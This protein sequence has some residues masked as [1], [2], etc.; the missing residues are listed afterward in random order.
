MT[1]SI[2]LL[3]REYNYRRAQVHLGQ[4]RIL[5]DEGKY[6][7]AEASLLESRRNFTHFGD[8]RLAAVTAELLGQVAEGRNQPEKAIDAYDESLRAYHEVKDVL[9]ATGVVTLLENYVTESGL[10]QESAAVA[11]RL[12]DEV[13]TRQYLARFPDKLLRWFRGVALIAALPLTFILTLLLG[14]AVLI[15]MQFTEGELL[16][17]VRGWSAGT[18]FRDVVLLTAIA[19]LPVLIALW[20]FRLVY[21]VTG[22]IIV[23]RV[24]RRLSPIEQEQP[25]LITCSDS[26]ISVYYPADGR[27][28]SLAWEDVVDIVP[29]DYF[30][31][32]RVI[33]LLSGAIVSARSGDR[34][35]LE[36]VTSG[37]RHIVNLV[38]HRL[39]LTTP[40]REQTPR[41]SF[42]FFE[43]R[44]TL[45]VLIVALLA[46]IALVAAGKVHP[47]YWVTDPVT[48]EMVPDTVVFT[49]VAGVADTLVPM[50]ILLGSAVTLWRVAGHQHWISKLYAGGYRSIP[51]WLV[52]LGAMLLT[53]AT[54]AW[55]VALYNANP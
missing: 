3:P 16:L 10:P 14:M 54:V 24:G 53:L 8:K 25:H 33:E 43:R 35:T 52:V 1:K 39:G 42:L 44:S 29:I 13:T 45:V 41:H 46:G 26:G 48:K 19:T 51:T 5:L 31:R 4:G 32:G 37:Y 47:L 12:I 11:K 27:K 38:R 9:A 36:G 22:A 50:V 55:L 30:L 23:R 2:T 18:P 15:Q 49:P 6:D 20:F 34:L 17:L 28:S 7:E 40:V 21:M